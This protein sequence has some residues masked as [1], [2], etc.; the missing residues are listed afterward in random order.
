METTV[1]KGA[2]KDYQTQDLSAK[3]TTSLPQRDKEML[4]ENFEEHDMGVS[5][6]NS[7]EGKAHRAEMETEAGPL[8]G[9]NESLPTDGSSPPSP[10]PILCPLIDSTSCSLPVAF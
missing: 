10:V 3:I 6:G 8:C 9:A 2:T 4:R 1:H 5:C 7:A